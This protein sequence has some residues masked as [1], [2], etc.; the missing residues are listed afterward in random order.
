MDSVLGALQVQVI[1]LPSLRV[2]I[3][4]DATIVVWVT[5]NFHKVDRQAGRN[6]I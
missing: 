1:T 2:Q 3:Q 6:E 4:K 5:Q